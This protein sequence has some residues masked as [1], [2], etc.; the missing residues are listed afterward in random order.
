MVWQDVFMSVCPY[1]PVFPCLFISSLACPQEGNMLNPK[2][3]QKCFKF[4]N[5]SKLGDSLSV[6][7]DAL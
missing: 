4:S 3:L 6:I 1:G 7:R 2:T 5:G